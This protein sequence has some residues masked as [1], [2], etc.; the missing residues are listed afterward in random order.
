MHS[1]QLTISGR[2]TYLPL[3]FLSIQIPPEPHSP[4]SLEHAANATC[5][6]SFNL[7]SLLLLSLNLTPL[8]IK[9]FSPATASAVFAN[10]SSIG[11]TLSTRVHHRPRSDAW[12]GSK[13][14]PKI[15][16]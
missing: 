14:L 1:R 12:T 5:F 15:F 7:A 10:A 13:P 9:N 6:E 16:T 3:I 2:A 4:E 11:F 8:I